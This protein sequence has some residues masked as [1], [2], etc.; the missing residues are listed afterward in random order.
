VLNAASINSLTIGKDM[1]GQITD[2]GALPTVSI[3]GSL[4]GT[5][6]AASITTMRVGVDLAGLLNVSGLLGT[7]AVTG[8]TPGEIIAGDIDLITV[9]AG[10]GNKVFQVIEDGVQRQIDATP[11]GGGSMPADIH[12]SF[13]YDS[14]AAGNPSVAINVVNGGPVVEH[15][16]N[17]A[18]VSMTSKSNFNLALLTATGQSGISN[19]SVDGNLLVGV[20]A[21]E[22]K[23]F[24]LT[25]KSRTGIVLASDQ[26]TGVEVSGTLPI[27]MIDVGGIEAVAFGVLTT[28]KGKPVNIL[29]DLGS[30]GHPQVLWNL[31]GSKAHILAAT[32]ALVIPF[33]ASHPVQVYAQAVSS[34]P[35]LLYT[36]T[37]K[38]SLNDNLPITAYVQIKPAL[39]HHAVPSIASID[40]VGNGGSVI[41][42]YSVGSIT[43]T[44]P[45]GSVTVKSKG[46]I[47][48]ITAPSIIGK[49]VVPKGAGQVVI[50]TDPST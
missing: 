46:G 15:S 24:G 13:V 10:Y 29:G 32:D 17:L 34:N 27:G 45:L 37:L 31:L 30:K 42:R 4:S 49:I 1:A 23:F 21:A 5:L 43:S 47:G 39:T 41:S 25:A 35:S 11:V 48:S 50:H 3:G 14:T 26:I 16:F 18:L 9:Q 28:A 6:N 19:V 33:N 36:L 20:T 38:D 8:G 12:F 2:T 7:L 22:A 44:G 40:L